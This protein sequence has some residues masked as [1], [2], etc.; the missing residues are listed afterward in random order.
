MRT[1][2]IFATLI[3]IVVAM[4]VNNF[5]EEKTHSL[6]LKGRNKTHKTVSTPKG[7]NKKENVITK[8]LHEKEHKQAIFFHEIGTVRELLG[9][10]PINMRVDFGLG[11][12][13]LLNFQYKISE[14]LLNINKTLIPDDME[15]LREE[16]AEFSQEIMQ[17]PSGRS[18]RIHGIGRYGT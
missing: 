18:T 15:R 8:T 6:P 1:F 11:H 14:M 4:S 13:Q 17:D 9:V 2:T 5:N 16:F 3:S 7:R 10:Q 12:H